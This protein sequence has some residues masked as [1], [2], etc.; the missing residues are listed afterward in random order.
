ME[1]FIFQNP[2]KI[3]F[4]TD[5]VEQ[6]GKETAKHADKILL[7]Y[8]SKSIK[9]SGLYDK[10]IDLLKAENIEIFELGGVIPN[11]RLSLINE[12]I[13]IC[14][15]NNIDFILAVG[16]GSVIDSAKAIAIGAKYEGDVWDFFSK[17][18]CADGGLMLG[19]ILTLPATGSEMNERCVITNDATLEKR[20]TSTIYPTFSILDAQLFATL[21]KHQV[22]NG[23][24]DMLAHCMERYFTTSENVEITDRMLEGVMKTIID[25][26][27]SVYH[28]PSDYDKYSQILWAG[29]LAHNYS[30]CVGRTTDWAS[31]QIEHEVSGMYDVAHGAGLAVIFP[32]WMEYV[33]KEDV[34]RVAM[35]ANR[36]LNVDLDFFDFERTAIQGIEALKAFYRSLNMPLNFKELGIENPDI[37]NLA[38]NCTRNNTITQG[39]FKKLNTEDIEEI[40]KLANR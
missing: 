5:S 11:P 12:G 13:E 28:N 9:K 15:Q 25:L 4:G 29:T 37:K 7:H 6:V 14:K 22:A 19:T 23:I 31:H 35:F 36:V 26:G 20:G 38:L 39:V 34:T 3:I 33:Y 1:N 16:G 40:L 24:V 2:T 18:V 8:G 21:P 30:L 27:P 32:A 10:V 17:G